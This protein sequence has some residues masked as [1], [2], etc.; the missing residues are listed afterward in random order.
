MGYDF[1][2]LKGARQ[3]PTGVYM[4]PNFIGDVVID[5]ITMVRSQTEKD[6]YTVEFRIVTTNMPTEI[7]ID[8]KRTWQN[9]MA[10]KPAAGN[11]Q[12]FIAALFGIDKKDKA[13][14]D[15]L[16]EEVVALAAAS[17]DEK[18]NTEFLGVVVHLETINKPTKKG[19]PFTVHLW[20]PGTVKAPAPATPAA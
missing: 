9:D 11:V 10:Q 14:N 16:D 6:L 12:A 3:S 5:N 18:L 8:H 20:S 17:V 15:K 2:K 7:M 4:P 13:A 19:D 1:G